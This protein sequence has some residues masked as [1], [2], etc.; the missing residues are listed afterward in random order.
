VIVAGV[1]RV[2]LEEVASDRLYRR[3]AIEV[4]NDEPL[5][6]HA[7]ERLRARLRAAIADRSDGAME[8]PDTLSVG[9]LADLL[10]HQLRLPPESMR[11]LFAD[12][13]AARRAESALAAH[14]LG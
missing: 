8:L 9:Q 10:L 5:S 7:D 2:H 14:E 3:V 6:A 13:D 4:V 1:A 12:S 11:R